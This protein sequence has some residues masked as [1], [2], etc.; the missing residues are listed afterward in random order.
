MTYVVGAG[1]AVVQARNSYPFPTSTPREVAPNRGR[2]PLL[3][4]L[5]RTA[6]Y[7]AIYRSQPW[8][9]AV[10]NK[11]VYAIGRTP[12][13]TYVLGESD[14]RERAP[15]GNAVDQLM[16]K[17][18]RRGSGWSLKTKAM[19]DL[20][21]HGQALQVA[22][23]KA[24]A[25]PTELWPVP[26]RHVVT[27]EDESG[28]IGYKVRLPSGEY[29]VDPDRVVHFELPGCV[30][31]LEPLRRTLA[32]E[33]AALTW[34]GENFRNGITP[35]GAFVSELKLDAKTLPRLREE[36]EGLY[37]GAENAGRFGMFDQGLKWSQMGTSAV[38][39]ELLGQRKLD[40]EEVCGAYDI[41]PTAVGILDRAIMGNVRELRKQVYVDAVGPKAVL[42]ESTYN[43][44]LVDP[45]PD[46]DGYFVEFDMDGILRPDPEGR[47]RAHLMGQQSSTSTI[48]ERRRLENLPAI[49]HPAADAVLIPVNMTAV[50]VDL[51][52]DPAAP[53]APAPPGGGTLPER[54]TAEAFRESGAETGDP[55]PTVEQPTVEED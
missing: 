39:A 12:L 22:F 51:G 3:D 1:G 5:G 8:V 35:R 50:G 42:M 36:L 26:W 21:V 37:A 32:I 13:K 40:R 53:A 33:N 46:W 52:N 20:M 30:S 47:A 2:V 15:R 48:N 28:V 11:H 31:P 54:L 9:Y 17:P 10:V 55:V 25:P 14:D 44:Q 29:W 27:L 38:D 43:C 49:D 18:H 23:G 24:G 6:T 19:Y 7:E 16:R 34:Q 4:A 41:P 45:V